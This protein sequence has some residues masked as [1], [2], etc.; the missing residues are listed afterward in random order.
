LFTNISARKLHHTEVINLI[1]SVENL[2][3]NYRNADKV[4]KDQVAAFNF[5]QLSH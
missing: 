5:M 3:K 4:L 1:V 2:K